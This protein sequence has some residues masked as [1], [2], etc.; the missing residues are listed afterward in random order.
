VPNRHFLAAKDCVMRLGL[1]T[2][3][4]LTLGI[5]IGE[6][7]KTLKAVPHGRMFWAHALEMGLC[8]QQT[9]KLIQVPM[10]A[11]APY[12]TGLLHDIGY[13]AVAAHA[14]HLMASALNQGQGERT[15]LRL[16]E[17]LR[18]QGLDMAA[19]SA[20]LCQ[21]MT[22]PDFAVAAVRGH[23]SLE[24]QDPQGAAGAALLVLSETLLSET[25]AYTCFETPPGAELVESA[26]TLL[27]VTPEGLG[28]IR[29]YL[30]DRQAWLHSIAS[31][32]GA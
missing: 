1:V 13:L 32:L 14:P 30:A 17:V 12:L 29:A 11:G 7:L 25:G 2:A 18:A 20:D 31:A 3:R 15:P 19:L 5:V 27:G 16:D 22:L 23:D 9:A 28:V 26:A 4:D 8:N 21:G 24:C 10:P 6:G